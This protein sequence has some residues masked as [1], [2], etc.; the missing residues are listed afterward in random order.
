MSH[1]RLHQE[2]PPDP[3]SDAPVT[4]RFPAA[5]ATARRTLVGAVVHALPRSENDNPDVLARI[6]VESTDEVIRNVERTLARMQS[7]LDRLRDDADALTDSYRF[8]D[9][10]DDGPRAA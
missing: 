3:S 8:P 9:P 4:F 6:G 5:M 1:L 2:E 10:V 7:S